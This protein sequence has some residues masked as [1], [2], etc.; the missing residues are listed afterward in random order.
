MRKVV[1]END[2]R[3]ARINPRSIVG[4]GSFKIVCSGEYID[5]DRNGQPCVAKS[6]RA[7]LSFAKAFDKELEI[8]QKARELIKKFND[9]KIID[10]RVLLNIPEVWE[11]DHHGQVLIEPFL[12]NFENFNSNTGH[13]TESNSPWARVM[14]ALSHFS[15]HVSSGQFLLCDLQGA[16]YS[17]KLVL[18]D[19]VVMSRNGR[20]GPA[21]LGSEGMENFF[22]WH[23]CTEYCHPNWQ[24]PKK[25]RYYHQPRMGTSMTDGV[26]FIVPTRSTR[27]SLDTAIPTLDGRTKPTG[28]STTVKQEF[29][30]L[31]PD[32]PSWLAQKSFDAVFSGMLIQV[33]K[34]CEY[35]AW[36]CLH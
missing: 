18:T 19:P 5:G 23:N 4:Q 26:K 10:K 6:M 30:D 25:A 29:T 31:E 15:Y 14:Q 16:V 27:S 35:H 2:A 28:W 7:P 9:S 32:T 8:I 24:V 12:K 11:D 33:L 36:C 17:H 22:H 34:S 1:R 3:T 13:V 21:D 20:F